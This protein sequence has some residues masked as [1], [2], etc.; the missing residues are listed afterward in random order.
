MND[1]NLQHFESWLKEEL[2]ALEP[3]D[4]G[5]SQQVIAKIETAQFQTAQLEAVA[6]QRTT[7]RWNMVSLLVCMVA[8]GTLLIQSLSQIDT[9]LLSGPILESLLLLVAMM[10]VSWQFQ[11]YWHEGL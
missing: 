3:L 5:F 8:F 6:S 2:R 7:E 11:T 1:N 10:A 9:L 4:D